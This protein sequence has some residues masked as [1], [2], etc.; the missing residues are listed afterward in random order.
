MTSL[1][2]LCLACAQGKARDSRQDPSP[3]DVR[4]VTVDEG[5]KLEVLNWGGSGRPIILL[6][7]SGHSAHVFDGFAE[8]LAATGHVYGITRRG[9][10]ASSTPASGYS[11][12][13]LAQDVVQVIDALG[14]RGATLVGHSMAGEELTR[15]GIDHA[16]RASGL[17]YLDAAGDPTDAPPS[18]PAYMELFRALPAR[19][20]GP[21]PPAQA[22]M[23]SP[24]AFN[25][26]RV[27]HHDMALPE[28][29]LLNTYVTSPTGALLRFKASR[30][31]HEAVGAGAEKRDYAS[32]KLPVLAMFATRC[33]PPR[34]TAEYACVGRASTPPDL[35]PRDAQERA[36]IKAFEDATDVYINRWKASLR[37]APA[38]VRIVDLSGANHY[39]FLSNGTDVLNE[40]R[41]F[42]AH[43]R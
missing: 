33:S 10:G 4:F 11:E 36:A 18:S 32:V 2:L 40:I 17:V 1:L 14:L 23:E 38:G 15:I 39:V 12:R 28:S 3:H 13:R 34:D 42:V 8:Q 30:E 22:D 25:A 35:E 27:R 20:Q 9:Y 29:E 16:D 43:P 6:A 37:R 24:K 21:P 31:V 19:M 7:G 41:R 5:V 26:W